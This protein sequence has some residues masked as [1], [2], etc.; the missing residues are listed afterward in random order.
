MSDRNQTSM[1][2]LILISTNGVLLTNSFN[3]DLIKLN[4]CNICIGMLVVHLR[5]I[6]AVYYVKGDFFTDFGMFWKLSLSA[7]YL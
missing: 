7:L 2:T 3:F 6:Q 1:L 5:K 4:V